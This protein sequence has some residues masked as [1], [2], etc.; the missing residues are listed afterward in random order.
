MSVKQT[1]KGNGFSFLFLGESIILE[2][3]QKIQHLY[4][5]HNI[6]LPEHLDWIR[7]LSFLWADKTFYFLLQQ[8]TTRT[9][10]N[11]ELSFDLN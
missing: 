8:Q 6:Y 3:S 5:I 2:N 1:Y 10:P 9:R 7:E 4:I 11:K